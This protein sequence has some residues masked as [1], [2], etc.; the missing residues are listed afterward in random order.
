[1]TVRW[2]QECRKTTHHDHTKHGW[3]K[4]AVCGYVG[5][6]LTKDG[7]SIDK[8]PEGKPLVEVL[9]HTQICP[10]WGHVY[11]EPSSDRVVESEGE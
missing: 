2:C 9:A 10:K 7:K 8:V 4:C 1:M 6:F 3:V 5:G 11:E